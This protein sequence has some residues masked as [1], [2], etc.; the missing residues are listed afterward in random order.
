M[1]RT[2]PA[3]LLLLQGSLG[4]R[5]H[6]PGSAAGD[7]ELI[8]VTV[9]VQKQA[10]EAKAPGAS[11]TQP[12][13]GAVATAV[14]QALAAGAFALATGRLVWALAGLPLVPPLYLGSRDGLAAL[15]PPKP[16]VGDTSAGAVLS[17]LK[18][19]PPGPAGS[20]LAGK[21]YRRRWGFGA[22]GA[23]AM[24]YAD[25]AR[26]ECVHRAGCSSSCFV[27]FLAATFA[28]AL[29]VWAVTENLPCPD[30]AQFWR[31]TASE[32]HLQ[33]AVL[34]LTDKGMAN[35]SKSTGPV[36]VARLA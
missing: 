9:A 25:K 1:P 16:G 8:P 28:I 18:M 5:M 4:S 19:G 14:L 22:T 33:H 26:K 11:P 23:H 2:L 17:P 10:G 32:A 36:A 29:M 6:A 24:A 15:K 12:P 21:H 35:L 27:V 31:P 34:S 3:L 7:T 30:V 20:E 13:G